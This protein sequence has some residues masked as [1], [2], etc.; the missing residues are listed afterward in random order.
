ML[1]CLITIL[2]VQLHLPFFKAKI[3]PSTDRF[4]ILFLA[5]A[6]SQIAIF[7]RESSLEHILSTKAEQILS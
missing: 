2:P 7:I 4:R 3:E 1:A 5:R 6:T